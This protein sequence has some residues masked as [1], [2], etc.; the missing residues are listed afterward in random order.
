MLSSEFPCDIYSFPDLWSY[1]W[2]TQG[3]ALWA[4]DTSYDRVQASPGKCHPISN[5]TFWGRIS[6]HMFFVFFKI[7]T[8][9]LQLP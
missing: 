7:H 4:E 2:Q 5:I 8:S 9:Q 6:F 3:R 1:P